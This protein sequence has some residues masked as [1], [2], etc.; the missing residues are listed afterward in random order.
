MT[1]HIELEK[2]EDSHVK[3]KEENGRATIV[4]LSCLCMI[5]VVN[6]VHLKTA[7]AECL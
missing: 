6:P 4:S 7:A 2:E 1:T 3:E 5:A